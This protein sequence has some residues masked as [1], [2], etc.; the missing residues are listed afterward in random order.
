MPRTLAELKEHLEMRIGTLQSMNI[1]QK[2]SDFLY[3]VNKFFRIGDEQ[4]EEIKRKKLELE[5]IN[6]KKEIAKYE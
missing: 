5:I 1:V 6:I 4:E 2:E 3:K